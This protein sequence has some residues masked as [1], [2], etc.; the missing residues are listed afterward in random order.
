MNKKEAVFVRVVWDFFTKEGRH[1]LPWRKTSNPYRI[2]VS[3]IMLQQTQVDR[4]LP[5]YKQFIQRFPTVDILA[6]ASLAEVLAVWQGLGYNRRAKML[7]ACAIEI[8]N[9][10][11]G[12]F[13]RTVSELEA[14]PG[15]GPY[16]AA[17][18]MAF[19]FNEPIPLIETNVRSVY[20]HHFFKEKTQVSDKEILPIIEHTMDK[21]RIREWYWALMDYGAWIKK[22]L[23]NPNS[24]SSSYTQQGTFKGSNRQLRGEIIRHLLQGGQTRM[25]LVRKLKQ[26]ET[27]RVDAQLYQLLGEEMI[28]KKERRFY[29]P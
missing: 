18:V 28:I 11:K 15:V 22:T 10:H 13:P 27:D 16:T 2:L 19:A 5:K 29:L 4:V 24:Q 26:F 12:K 14:L 25:T 21:K 9:T 8:V 7:H 1:T 6:Q 20:L 3:E 17:A 23:G